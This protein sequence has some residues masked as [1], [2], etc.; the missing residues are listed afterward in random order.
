MSLNHISFYQQTDINEVISIERYQHGNTT[1]VISIYW[2]WNKL[3]EMS[4]VTLHCD[5]N[6]VL[7]WTDLLPACHISTQ[8]TNTQ[9]H[10]KLPLTYPNVILT[11]ILWNYLGKMNKVTSTEWRIFCVNCLM[12]LLQEQMGSVLLLAPLT[13]LSHPRPDPCKIPVGLHYDTVWKSI[14]ESGVK[15]VSV[16]REGYGG[17][18]GL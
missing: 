13:P 10:Q 9:A 8:I 7:A 1:R 4:K 18:V 2:Q 12:K 14:Q 5:I 6:I 3:G 11:L 17:G 15:L 16:L